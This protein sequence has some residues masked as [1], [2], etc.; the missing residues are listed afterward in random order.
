MERLAGKTVVITG[1]GSGLGRE[2]SRL[3]AREGANVVVMD[4]VPGRAKAVADEIVEAGGSSVFFDGDVANEADVKATVA[5]AVETYGGLDIM[6]ANAG[7]F[8][9]NRGATAFEDLEADEWADVLSTNITGAMWSA[10]HAIPHLRK[11][12][13]GS[14]LFT[15]SSNAIRA[16]PGTH[17]YAATKGAINALTI[18]LARELGPYGIR[19]NCINPFFGMSVNFMLDREAAVVGKSYE[20]S[21]TWDPK[22]APTP[23]ELPD[24][25]RIIDHALYALFLVSDEARWVSGQTVSTVDGANENNAAIQ[26]GDDWVEHLIGGETGS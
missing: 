21:G 16:M 23:L 22:A 20:E 8:L 24:A 26:F 5:L 25:P 11:R 2:G 9:K 15:G 13:G 17:A 7:H 10:K 14:I 19:V 18:N 12:G 6:W 1:G 3:F 4:R